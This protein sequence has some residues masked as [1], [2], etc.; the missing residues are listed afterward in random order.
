MDPE[1]RFTF[2]GQELMSEVAVDQGRTPKWDSNHRYEFDIINETAEEE[3]LKV[4]ICN[5]K[6][7][8]T[9]R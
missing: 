9:P 3:V 6:N 2:Q 4:E 8:G 1:V 5:F 7:V